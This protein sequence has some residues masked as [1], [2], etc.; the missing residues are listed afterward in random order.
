MRTH[1]LPPELRGLPT[2]IARKWVQVGPPTSGPGTVEGA[3][4]DRE[5]NL[6]MGVKP[7]GE[8]PQILKITPDGQVKKLYEQDHGHLIGVA[9]HKDGRIFLCD[10]KG[11]FPVISPEGEFI[12]DLL[13]Q[14]GV[15]DLH[16]ND[17]CFD[18]KGDLYVTDFHDR[19]LNYEGGLYKFTQ[20]SDYKECIKLCGDMM[21]PNGIG[22]S[23]DEKYLWTAETVP[24]TIIRCQ[25][26]PEN[27]IRPMF[28]GVK[29][30][31][32]ANGSDMCDSLK[33][34]DDGNVYVAMMYGGRCIVTD[35]EGI[36]IAN[37]VIEDRYDDHCMKSPNLAIHPEKKKGYM[38]CC[39]TDGAWLYE[40]DTFAP[41]GHMYAFQ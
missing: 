11:G 39:G 3:E 30:V 6:I 38:L 8:N 40:F 9:I 15:P 17:I 37:V 27:L 25:L 34:D 31:Y 1:L 4:F 28:L 10:I 12:R 13:D 20:E 5:G 23:P 22:L 33:V 2:C 29:R 19:P 35:D 14:P 21:T 7:V 26:T 16:P 24:N 32:H 18:S 41:A 36:P